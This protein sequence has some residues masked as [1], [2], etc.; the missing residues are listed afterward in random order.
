MTTPKFDSR[1]SIGH[2]IQVIMLIVAGA[3]AWTRFETG[4]EANRREI[5]RLGLQFNETAKL[6]LDLK[7]SVSRQDERLTGIYALLNRIDTRLER[8]ENR[9]N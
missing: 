6:T 1:I 8:I 3:I 9:G 4:I 2:I 7:D 5:G